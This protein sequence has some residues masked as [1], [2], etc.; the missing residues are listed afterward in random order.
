MTSFRATDAVQ[1]IG[2]IK[3]FVEPV[4]HLQDQHPF[5]HGHAWQGEE[6]AKRPGNFFTRKA[7]NR[8]QPPLG[9]EQH[10]FQHEHPVVFKQTPG[11]P[12]FWAV[13][14]RFP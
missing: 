7:A 10:A 3:A 9:F 11:T 8:T 13:S 6:S 14:R 12:V 5:I 2:E 1:G 4:Q